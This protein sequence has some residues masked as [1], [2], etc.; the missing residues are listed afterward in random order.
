MGLSLDYGDHFHQLWSRKSVHYLFETF[1]L[2][3][4]RQTGVKTYL[5]SGGN[6]HH[7]VEIVRCCVIIHHYKLPVIVALPL[8]SLV[9]HDV[10]YPVEINWHIIVRIHLMTLFSVHPMANK[11]IVYAKLM[12]FLNL[13]ADMKWS[14]T[15]WQSFWKWTSLFEFGRHVYVNQ[16][17][18]FVK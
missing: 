4:D 17:W 18:L 1:C 15:Y 8:F 7:N 5:P 6:N 16:G 14:L 3:I 11:L 12:P 2:Q 13:E 10:D 9:L